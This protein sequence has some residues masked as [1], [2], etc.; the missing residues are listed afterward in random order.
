MV[1]RTAS[2]ANTEFTLRSLTAAVN[3]YLVERSLVFG[4][5]E[6]DKPFL[7]FDP[8]E[9]LFLTVNGY[10]ITMSHSMS[11]RRKRCAGLH[12]RFQRLL[13][14]ADL[15]EY[16]TFYARKVFAARLH[17]SGASLQ[18]IG[19]LLG[20]GRQVRV[21]RMIDGV[22]VRSNGIDRLARIVAQLI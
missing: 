6:H 18:E 20:V 10:P 21:K 3:A 22:P 15:R 13:R 9:R 4:G 11:K 2:R 8:E 7:G 16:S 1:V 19:L 17:A 14:A 5:Y 12:E